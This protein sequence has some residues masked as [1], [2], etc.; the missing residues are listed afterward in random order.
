[1]RQDELKRVSDAARQAV[2]EQRYVLT[3]HALLEMHV[4]QL[5]AVDVES[6][7]LTGTIERVFADDPR[8]PRY[9]IVG[10]ATDLSRLVAVV[11]RFAGPLLVITVYEIRS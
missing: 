3:P 10:R 2:L 11:V 5:D 8:G 7:V 6:A 4:D 1:V 9:E